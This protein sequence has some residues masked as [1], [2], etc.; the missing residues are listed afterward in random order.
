MPNIHHASSNIASDEICVHALEIRRRK[1][2]PYQHAI[3]KARS[4]SLNL[5]L[6]PLQHVRL[7]SVRHM[8][9]SPGGVLACGRPRAIEQTWLRQQYKWTIG[10]PAHPNCLFRLGN[11]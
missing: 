4:E 7:G 8:A 9:I 2:A 3:T 11:L 6:H 10:V 1:C 5:V